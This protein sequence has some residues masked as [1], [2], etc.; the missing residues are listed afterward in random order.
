MILD[1]RAGQREPMIGAQQPHR[2][3]RRRAGVLDRLRFVEDD[4]VE[5]VVLERGHVAP[6][7]AVGGE[8]Q[9]GVGD[10]VDRPSCRSACAKSSTRSPGA[11]ACRFARPVED[12]RARHHH[13]RRLGCPRGIVRAG[14]EHRQHHDGLAEPHV[15]GKAAAESEVAQEAHPAERLTLIVTQSPQNVAGASSAARL[16]SG[17]IASRARAKP[18]SQIDVGCAASSASMSA[19]CDG[20]KRTPSTSARRAPAPVRP[21]E[22]LFG[23]HADRCR[24]RASRC[25]GRS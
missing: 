9:I 22:P 24:R 20:L 11:N 1:R 3:R 4:V 15:V 12:E 21:R 7:R 25:G 5:R 23:Q 14:F 17:C 10:R 6:Q 16:R 13:E 19:T 8:H 2:F 18:S